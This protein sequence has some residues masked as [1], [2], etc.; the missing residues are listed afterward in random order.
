LSS[1]PSEADSQDVDKLRQLLAVQFNVWESHPRKR[2][3]SRIEPYHPQI[4]DDNFTFD[5][6][7]G[8]DLP[9][10]VEANGPH[11]PGVAESECNVTRPE[12]RILSMPS[13]WP[14]GDN[15][16]RAVELELRIHQ[17][18]RSLETLRDLIA[19]KS[20]QYSHVIRIAPRKGV[21][22][23]ARSTIAKLNH[24][25]SYHC[26]VYGMSRTAMVNLKADAA[27]LKK[28]RTLEREDI[29]S[30]TALLNPNEPGSSKLKLSWIWQTG[31]T[32]DQGG[33]EVLRE[34]KCLE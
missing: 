29:R 16:Y 26:R 10:Q 9:S 17:A 28:Y 6:L 33:S 8:P 15:S 5:D 3:E 31:S 25:I 34:C 18:A 19:D 12:H 1:E 23:R 2:S 11:I 22:T 30:S 27:L 14:S 32:G 4:V 20:F 13:T 24:R 21:R 7:D